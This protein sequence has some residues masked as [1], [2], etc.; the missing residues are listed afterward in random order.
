M[1]TRNQTDPEIKNRL[2][3]NQKGLCMYCGV[4]LAKNFANVEV[5]HKTPLSRNGKDTESNLQ[6]TCVACNRRKLDC[7]DGEYRT[8]YPGIGKSKKPPATRIPQ[9]YFRKRRRE[10]EDIAKVQRKRRTARSLRQ[11]PQ[12]Y[13]DYALS[14]EEEMSLEYLHFL[15]EEGLA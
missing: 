2:Y 10:L 13:D 7:K 3:R 6:L 5:D 15:G 1:T 9:S 4:G 12:I 8:L 11:T 14:M